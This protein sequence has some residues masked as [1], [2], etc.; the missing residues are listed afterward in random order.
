M[1]QILGVEGN[2]LPERAGNTRKLLAE[3][4]LS[5]FPD[6]S[7]LVDELSR[8]FEIREFQLGDELLKYDGFPIVKNSVDTPANYSSLHI[9]CQGQARLLALDA[10]SQ[11]EVPTLLLEAKYSYGADELLYN[12]P[13]PYRAIAASAGVIASIPTA[14]LKPWLNKLPELQDYLQQATQK[15]QS[16]IFFKTLTELRSLSSHALKRLLPYITE[17][18]IQ[19]GKTLEANGRFWLRSGQIQKK[20]SSSQAPPGIGDSWDGS[21]PVSADWIAETDLWVYQLSNVHWESAQVIAPVL[22][23]GQRSKGEYQF[24]FSPAS[25]TPSPVKSS[26]TTSK[27]IPFPQPTKGRKLGFG[28]RYPFIQQQSTADCGAAC[29]AMVAQYWGKRLNMNMLRNVALVGRSGA[30]LKSLAAAAENIGFQARPV[31][32]SFNRLANQINPWIAHWQGDHYIV[33]YRKNKKSVLIA[34]PGLG[35]RSLSIREFQAG[36][37]GYALLLDPTDILQKTPSAKPSLGKFWGAFLPYRSL[38][39]PIFLASLL[40]QVFGLM[41]PLFTQIILDQVVVH[42]SLPTL[43]VFILGLLLFSIWRIGLV[44]IRQYLLDYFSNRVDLTLISAFISHA[45]NLPLQ[46]FA[47]RHV[48]DIVTRVQENEKIQLFLTRRAFTAWLD[49]LMAVVYIGLMAYYNWHLTLLVLALLPPIIILT[50]VASPF[51]R[52]VSR[53]IFNEAAKQNSS[54]VEILTGVATVKTSAAERELRWLWEDHLT[55]MFNAKFRGQK[56]AN[57]LQIA[58]ALINTLGST[59]LLWYGAT[60]VIQDQLSIGQFVAFNMLIGNVINPVLSLVGL[61]DELQE[62]MVSVERLDD[63][64]SAQ[65]EESADKPLLTLPPLQGEVKFE[66]VT[67]RYTADEERNTLQNISFEAHKSQTIAIVGRSGSGKTTLV[68]LLQGL[69]H[70]TSGR[71]LMDGHDIRHTSPHSLRCQLGVV[72]QECFLFSGTILENITLYRP[73]YSLEDAIEVAKLAEAHAFIQNL[74][75]GYNTKVGERGSSLSGGQRQRIAIARA[76]LTNPRILILDEATSSLDTESERRFQQNLRRISLERTTF[77]IA[78][79]L[80]TV[81]NADCILVLDRGLIVENGT[82]DQLMMLHGLYYQLAQQQI[83]V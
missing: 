39:L 2:V 28:Q 7:N 65:P 33:V 42:K 69:Y 38:L 22:G 17:T 72:P 32:A 71:I 43:N 58:G 13:L 20:A 26:P 81:R 19:K 64:F 44:G 21:N 68:N 80:S 74:P 10:V 6:K 83:D 63:I 50:V 14:K 41:T 73:E 27:V 78:H 36:W 31:R 5:L 12:Q 11:K 48:G 51:L 60:L 62:V 29:L 8:E 55:S 66:N 61:W 18:H 34:D 24:K 30:S 70:P 4:L 37:T 52:R 35:K 49:A 82:H 15:R 59:A 57:G 40:L 45:L 9:I 25:P 75:L 1:K 46:F 56:L 79:R 23:Q 53:E 3:I 67:F 16:L 76:L 77:I 47:S 54:L